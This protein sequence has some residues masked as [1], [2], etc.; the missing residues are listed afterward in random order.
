[1]AGI[2]RSS[3]LRRAAVCLLGTFASLT[4]GAV[5]WPPPEDVQQRLDEA[6]AM[7][8]Q[9][10][11]AV[12]APTS[13][14]ASLAD[15]L[16]YDFDAA[17]DYVRDRVR[18][19]PYRGVLRGPD[20]TAAALRGN[21]WD[22]ALLLAALINTM[23][24]DAQL[25]SGTLSPADASRLLQ[26]AFD[27]GP[28]DDDE[29][30]A[31]KLIGIVNDYDREMVTLVRQRLEAWQ[32]E[33]DANTLEKETAAIADEL[34]S[35]LNDAG[36]R[37]P[38]EEASTALVEELSDDYVWVRW[39][40][41]P[42]SPWVNLHPTFADE[43]ATQPERYLSGEVPAEFQHR[44]AL[45]LQIERST[46]TG[47]VERVA[48][49]DRFERPTAQLFKK[50]LSLGMGPLNPEVGSETAFVVPFLGDGV[51]PG[52]K[53]VT[54]LG[55]TADVGDA[56]GAPAALFATLSS[57]LGG[58]LSSLDKATG[59]ETE[60][61]PRLTGVLLQVE[62]ISPGAEPVVVERRLA[63]M[64]DEPPTELPASASFGLVLDVDVG[65][66]SSANVSHRLIRQEKALL[67]AL[68]I[69][70]T[71]ARKGISLEEAGKSPEFR[72]LDQA[73]WADFELFA[74]ALLGESSTA[75]IVFRPGPL[76]AARHTFR[77]AHKGML[78]TSDILSNPVTVLHRKADG[79][80]IESAS[81]AV[82][83]GVR[84]TLL[85]SHLVSSKRLWSQRRPEYV[86]QHPA[87]LERTAIAE[88]WPLAAKEMA[89]A[90][91]ASGFILGVTGDA[92][93]HWWR[94]DRHS[95]Q[96]LGM[97][98]FGGQ[99]VAEYV[100]M[101]SAAALSSY[102]FYQSV[103]SCDETYAD[104]R[105]MADCCIVGNLVGTYGVAALGGAMSLPAGPAQAYLQHPWAA[106]IGYITAALSFE[107]S[108]NMAIGAASVKP[109]A[110]ICRSYLRQ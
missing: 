105:E 46:G 25:V 69:L 34:L 50:Q 102:L 89:E 61:A 5:I 94:I 71:L 28:P 70:Y 90:D 91:L 74:S 42:G 47:S 10:A 54:A 44:V 110:S 76:L 109:I 22:Q 31:E 15:R 80:L 59:G 45:Q 52:G 6:I 63:E 37:L 17:I 48:V 97:G 108:Y 78:T 2:N 99:S 107:M 13:D 93:P 79:N 8:D 96:T 7:L 43:P 27:A 36:I 86:I 72:E 23:G 51:A 16:D 88:T 19:E 68:P 55:L 100:I 32:A 75:Q 35:L 18:Y 14:V 104:N 9:I 33:S 85:E 64:R 20:G 11:A 92:D 57:R 49:M 26:T 81:M 77:D 95:G 67:Q 1:M 29:F 3:L 53:A 39:R 4:A 82:L 73:V 41:G 24:G 103:Q 66:E 12:P 87:D 38:G 62:I 30:D 98:T 65:P 56:S 60:K 84:E 40:D 21:A 58:A 101:T 106:S 83:Q